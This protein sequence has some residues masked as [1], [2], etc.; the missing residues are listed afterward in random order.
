M[1]ARRDR[2]GPRLR[3]WGAHWLGAD[4]SA[5]AGSRPPWR[6]YGWA[7]VA[8]ALCTL[9]NRLLFGNVPE[10]TLIMLYLLGLLP[11]ALRGNLGAASFAA[12]LA[13]LAF[14]FFFT[15]PYLT[16][17]V[18]DLS[19]LFTFA[20]MGVIGVVISSLTSR[21]SGKIA[22]LKR[23]ESELAHRADELLHANRALRDAD[24][25]KDEFLAALSHELRTPLSS[26]IG[27]GT[28]LAE[29]DAGPINQ[30]QQLYLDQVLAG[31]QQMNAK[32][33]DLLELGRIQAG[34][35]QLACSATEYPPVILEALRDLE[36]KAAEKGVALEVGVDVP[37]E[38]VLDGER[39]I[40]VVHNLVDNAVKFTPRGGKVTL[41][42]W[43]EG[44]SVITEVRDTGIGIPEE[45][46]ARL[47]VR[48]QQ[49]DMGTTREVGGLGIGLAI[50]KAIVEAH[51]GRLNV[52]SELGKGSRF[53]FSLPLQRVPA[54][55]VRYDH[56]TR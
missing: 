42:A 4:S 41:R 12:V 52:A 38:L 24:R 56:L 26:V 10:A 46:L 30:D 2:A 23:A 3:E 36:E 35:F 53:W 37:G 28:M 55:P 32:V 51:G 22:A 29:G 9:L 19:Y 48:F 16:L 54:E 49:A 33:R 43:I 44:D 31:A 11:V 27:F 8:V 39:V 47:F 1:A 21:L 20:T 34:K 6:A 13:V 18:Y 25:H 7:L 45:V 17:R 5:V 15:A 40:E 50:C 14:N